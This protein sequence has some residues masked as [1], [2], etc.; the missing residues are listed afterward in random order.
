MRSTPAREEYTDAAKFFLDEWPGILKNWGFTKTAGRLH[1]LLLISPKPMSSDELVATAGASRGSISTQITAL[2]SAGLVERLKLLGQ[3]QQLF[4]ALRDGE[5]IQTALASHLARRAI[6]PI[7]QLDQSLSAIT[8]TND[9][10]WYLAIHNLGI[11]F[12]GGGETRR[13]KGP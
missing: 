8:E 1:G 6:E 13:M 11:T 5:A 2:E 4:V 9:L 3:R 10:P 12:N 7:V